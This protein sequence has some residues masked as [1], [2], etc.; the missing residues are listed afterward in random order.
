MGSRLEGKVAF[1]TGACSGIGLAA[2]ELFIAEGARVLAADEPMFL[3]LPI[4]APKMPESDAPAPAERDLSMDFDLGGIS[5]D[6]NTPAPT[7]AQQSV[8]GAAE[9]LD[10]PEIGPGATTLAVM[11][12]RPFSRAID[13]VKAI[14]PPLVAA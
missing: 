10:L 1:I 9:S 7:E 14:R 11:P 12:L 3:D 4:D 13:R 6:L 8:S 2:T 5:L